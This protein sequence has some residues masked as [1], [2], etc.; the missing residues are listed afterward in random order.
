MAL[1]TVT[2]LPTAK[3][4]KT[5]IVEDI[6][7]QAIEAG[8]AIPPTAKGSDFDLKATALANALAVLTANQ[9]ELDTDS[10]PTRA[11]GPALDEIRIADGLPEVGP[12][13]ASG[14]VAVT[15]TSLSPI[16]IPDGLGL[17]FPG[18]V[19]AKILGTHLSVT[20]G[21][22]LPYVCVKTG[23]V[24]NLDAGTVGRFT[25]PVAGLAQDCTI[26]ADVRNGADIESDAKKRRRILNRRQNVPAAGNFGHLRELA[27]SATNAIDN[28]HVYPAL[29]GPGSC[30]VALSAPWY[31]GGAGQSRVA[32]A[33][34]IAIVSSVYT[35]ELPTDEHYYAVESVANE[36][37]DVRLALDV[38]P[39][40][41]SWMDVA[42]WP[43]VATTISAAALVSDTQFRVV[44]SSAAAAP[45]VGK[46]IAVWS[47]AELGFRFAKILTA[48]AVTTTTYDIT[49]TAWTGGDFT[50]I[51]GLQVSPAAG[52]MPAWG[53]ALLEAFGSQTPGENCL[54][55]QEPTALRKPVESLAEPAGFGAREIGAFISG[56]D[57]MVDA[58][59]EAINVDAPTRVTPGVA[60]NVLCLRSIS[61]GVA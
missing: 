8:Q 58:S 45:V 2:R 31:N 3:E 48:T 57:E 38:L 34:A 20:D 6:E 56:F 40:A 16:T 26:V 49:T 12:T 50:A 51:A 27:L 54:V 4:W 43:A 44:M 13:P 53:D 33:A 30:K 46:S 1:S 28:A 47:V 35:A 36:Y 14:S 59:I 37:V 29:G 24:G 7:L 61:L 52:N 19:T 21:A 18:A 55:S 22:E 17:L 60:P 25:A 42:P 15:V 10:D 9:V 41:A 5:Q 39:G 11:V 32:S 23:A